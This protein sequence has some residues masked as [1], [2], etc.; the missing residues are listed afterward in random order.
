MILNNVEQTYEFVDSILNPQGGG[1]RV[2]NDISDGESKA[3]SKK[4]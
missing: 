4:V 3:W 1:G 2:L